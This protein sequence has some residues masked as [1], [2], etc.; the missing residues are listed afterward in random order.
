MGGQPELFGRE[1]NSLGAGPEALLG[2][3]W[4]AATGWV[5][6]LGGWLGHAWV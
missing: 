2:G 5:L 1:P 4:V 3:C 6:L